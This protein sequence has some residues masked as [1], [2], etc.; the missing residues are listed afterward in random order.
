M[1]IWIEFTLFKNFLKSIAF[2]LELREKLDSIMACVYKYEDK[3]ICHLETV[4]N[5]IKNNTLKT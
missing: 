4:T 3:A 5:C 2:K 1:S